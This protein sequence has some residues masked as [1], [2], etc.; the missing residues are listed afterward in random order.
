[1]GLA[2]RTEGIAAKVIVTTDVALA[3][4]AAFPD[5]PGIVLIA[6]TGS[7]ALARDA[8]G[9]ERRAGGWGWQ[10]GDEGSGY[11]IGRAALAHVGRAADGR[12][13]HSAI[14]PHIMSWARAADMDTLVR[15]AKEASPAEVAAL[16]RAVIAAD[17]EQD[18]RAALILEGAAVD[19]TAQVRV[20]VRDLG[21]TPA[22]VALAGSLLG[23]DSPL[24]ARVVH[25]L[26][27]IEGVTVLDRYVDAV[28]GALRLAAAAA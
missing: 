15:W 21:V 19:L 11:A 4:E 1:L 8:A 16:A 18:T 14:V 26:Q 7:I 23:L 5:A 27:G 17:A 10:M 3:L 22:P 13:P 12:E 24:R 25:R 2:L 6:G 20:L 28:Q 9:L